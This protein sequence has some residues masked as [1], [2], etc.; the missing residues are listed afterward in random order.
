MIEISHLYKTYREADIVTPVFE[1]FSL[2]V[3]KG[4]FVILTGESGCG[5]STLISLLLLEFRPDSGTIYVAER[6]TG[7]IQDKDIHAYR[8]KIGAIFQD[9]RLLYDRNVYDNIR[10]AMIVAEAPLKDAQVRVW[11][12]AKLL[13]IT[14]LLKRRPGEL[15]GGEQQKVCLARAIVNHPTIL[16]ADEPTANLDPRSSDE[17]KNL[18]E[19][20]HEQGTTVLLVTQD[21]ILYDCK[22]SR[23]IE[24]TKLSAEKRI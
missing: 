2:D 21:N 1:D 19:T 3:E 24:L 23:R 16:L 11:N 8:R 18:L 7:R 20:V 6:D 14:E 15:S 9:Y 10:L 12:V 17:V 13:G 22:N 5:K 4:E